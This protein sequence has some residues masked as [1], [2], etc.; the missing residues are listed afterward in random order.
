MSFASGFDFIR[1]T[2]L[3]ACKGFVG[4]NFRQGIVDEL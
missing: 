2:F 1:H 3:C 4:V